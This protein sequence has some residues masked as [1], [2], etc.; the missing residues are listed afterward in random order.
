MLRFRV[1]FPILYVL[2]VKFTFAVVQI[3]DWHGGPC[4]S[5]TWQKNGGGTVQMVTATA[6]DWNQPIATAT[7][8]SGKKVTGGGG[9]CSFSNAILKRSSPS[10]NS[11][12]VAG[13]SQNT[14]QNQYYSVTTYALCQ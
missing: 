10:G 13:C 8:P 3:P 9:M 11:A 2:V 14:N 12:W 6:S 1:F 7:C 4:Q 5:G